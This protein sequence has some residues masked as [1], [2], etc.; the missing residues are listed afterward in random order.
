MW[1]HCFSHVICLSPRWRGGGGCWVWRADCQQFI[2]TPDLSH[3][4]LSHLAKRG[5]TEYITIKIELIGS[6]TDN[7]LYLTPGSAASITPLIYHYMLTCKTCNRLFLVFFSI[8]SVAAK[9][10]SK[11][12]IGFYS[13][14]PY[15]PENLVKFCFECVTF[16]KLQLSFHHYR[17]TRIVL[18]TELSNLQKTQQNFTKISAVLGEDWKK[19]PKN[20][21]NY[22]EY[23]LSKF[24][25]G[26]F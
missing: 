15:L 8:R 18:H 11:I 16:S 24:K 20:S 10:L 1:I 26:Y 4:S 21:H 2:L 22:V 23:Y 3:P 9:C 17:E 12:C 6:V 13:S 7:V 25:K 19:N 5:V 14:S